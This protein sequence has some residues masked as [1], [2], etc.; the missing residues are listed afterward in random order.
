MRHPFRN[1]LRQ[2]IVVLTVVGLVGYTLY[3]DALPLYGKSHLQV[4]AALPIQLVPS[5][6]TFAIWFVIFAGLIMYA[7]YQL[8]PRQTG[9]S[10]H[11]RTGFW[12]LV[13]AVGHCVWVHFW[14]MGDWQWALVGAV[15][16]LEALMAI[17]VRLEIGRIRV[18]RNE[19]LFVRLPFSIYLGWS[20][21]TTTITLAAFLNT[22]DWLP[23]ALQD[24]QWLLI[25]I[26]LLA[27]LVGF[28]AMR[29][30]DFVLALTVVWGLAGLGLRHQSNLTILLAV[31][32]LSAAVLLAVAAVPTD[33]RPHTLKF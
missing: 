31:I 1:R 3:A 26:T 5:P 23:I 17:Y 2:L 27:V 32:I 15:V 28:V 30:R 14:H 24:E 18:R 29:H 25:V 19:T 22:G 4:V 7:T 20:A 6:V 21:V 8:M 16:E 9:N 13:A 10:L 33:R 12:L 11:N